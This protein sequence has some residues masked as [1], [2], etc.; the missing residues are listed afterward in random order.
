MEIK[1][2][3]YRVVST[4]FLG[5]SEDGEDYKYEITFNQ[6]IVHTGRFSGIEEGLNR[7]RENEKKEYE[8]SIL[9][10]AELI[11]AKNKQ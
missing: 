5:V 11:K 3:N 8:E 6:S 1:E 2:K 9:K 4:K 7:Y 10:R